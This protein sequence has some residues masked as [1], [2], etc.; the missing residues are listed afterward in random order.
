MDLNFEISQLKNRNAD[1]TN[2]ISLQKRELDMLRN[3]V[4]VDPLL[5][6]Q[7]KNL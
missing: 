7:L 5:Q 6:E 2:E 3:K 4:G 1:L